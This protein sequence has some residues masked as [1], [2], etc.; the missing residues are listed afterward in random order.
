MSK[1][2]SETE[3]TSDVHGAAIIDG[4]ALSAEVRKEVAIEV[5]ELVAEG[6]DPSL[7]LVLIGTSPAARV[8]IK[9][10]LRAC[11]AVGIK[12]IRIDL[13]RNVSQE[14]LLLEI[15]RLN[16]DE[17][18]HGVLLQLPLPHHID[19]K[20]VIERI[21]P[22]KDVDGF[23]PCN[24]GKLNTGIDCLAPCTPASVPELIRRSGIEL[25]G[26]HAVIVG[27]SNFLGKP[28]M[29]LLVQQGKQGDCT[30]TC[31]HGQTEHLA[32]HTRQ[33]DILIAAIG[34]PNFVT[35]GMVK[36]G[37][38]VIDLG[39]NRIEDLEH[40]HG[41]RLVGDVDFASVKE[42]ASAITPVPG[43]VGPMTVAMLMKNTVKAAR[44]LSHQ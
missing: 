27:R 23:H 32:D 11:E 28:V 13:P 40:S 25:S 44:N 3:K 14:D 38:I 19:D 2:N 15:D 35:A 10:K 34:V 5:E 30:V 36:D 6:V 37:A 33:A 42:V 22:S 21:R 24:V 17:T 1:L 29:N 43:G 4:N 31:C 39:A 8:Y 41:A 18:I 26:K 12:P 16:S 20:I 9:S 7:A